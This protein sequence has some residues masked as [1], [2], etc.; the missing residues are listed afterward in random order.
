MAQHSM[1]LNLVAD[2]N[3]NDQRSNSSTNLE[4]LYETQGLLEQLEAIN[5]LEEQIDKN[6]ECITLQIN[7][8]Q[9]LRKMFEGF[10]RS[11]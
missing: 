1:I 2:H 4:H 9:I 7:E 5:A 11:L 6:Y 3:W 8:L 10:K